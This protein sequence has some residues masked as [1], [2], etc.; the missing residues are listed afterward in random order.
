VIS[1]VVPI[2]RETGELRGVLAIDLTLEQI[3]DFLR[4]LKISESGQAFIIEQSGE[5]IAS[6]APELPFVSTQQGRKRLNA[7]SSSNPLIKSAA[8]HLQQ[9]FGS[10]NRIEGS[11]QLIWRC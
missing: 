10:L 2:Y 1:P 8:Q 9:K 11:Q 6:S 7:T 5:I 3:S 4:S